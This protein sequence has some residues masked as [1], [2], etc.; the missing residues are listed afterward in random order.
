MIRVDVSHRLQVR[1]NVSVKLAQAQSRDLEDHVN[2]RRP[3]SFSAQPQVVGNLRPQHVAQELGVENVQGHEVVFRRVAREHCFKSI[4]G[5]R[6]GEWE[7]EGVVREV[8]LLL[9]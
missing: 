8:L 5:G 9:C 7:E 2:A 6:E 1:D 4:L 3:D